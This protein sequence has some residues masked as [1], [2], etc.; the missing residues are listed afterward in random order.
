[1]QINRVG[2]GLI[3]FF[4]LAGIALAAVPIA[5]GVDGQVAAILASIGIIWVL[6]AGGLIWFA[7]RQKRKAAH[8]D[9]VFQNGIKGT[10]TVLEASSN[11]TVNEMPLLKLEL[12]LAVPGMGE[13]RVKRRELVSV[14]AARRFEPGLVLPV[15]VNP[16]DPDDFVLVW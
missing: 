16:E 10:A 5:I 7:K 8:Q 15:H 4:M 11:T 3:A 13:R 9:W 1:M 12:Q 6:V 2:I 14:F